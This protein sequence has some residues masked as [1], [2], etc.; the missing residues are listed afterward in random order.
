MV[1]QESA[2]RKVWK[3]DK[4]RE[5]TNMLSERKGFGV[6]VSNTR[7][8]EFFNSGSENGSTRSHI[9]R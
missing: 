3:E 1:A 7:I 5:N 9:R 4:T 6:L 8:W 2:K